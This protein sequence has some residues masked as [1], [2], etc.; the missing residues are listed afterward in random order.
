FQTALEKARS[1]VLE[2]MVE[3][4]IE[5]QGE[6][7]GDITADLAGR[8]GRISDTNANPNGH[9]V[10]SGLVPLS[11]L[12]DYSSRLKAI[13]GGEGS[14]EIGFSHYD[15]VPGNI[16]QSLTQQYQQGRHERE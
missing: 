12:D 4:K 15:P 11:E 8:R 13:T 10:I 16:Q 6:A 9:M 5:A 7:M 2:P 14:Y 3:I 1:I